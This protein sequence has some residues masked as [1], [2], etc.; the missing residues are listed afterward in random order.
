MMA[1]D[2][3]WR[4]GRQLARIMIISLHVL[5]GQV[6]LS[7]CFCFDANRCS[8]RQKFDSVQ[9]SLLHRRPRHIGHVQLNLGQVLPDDN[10]DTEETQ[11]G[12]LD[13]LSAAATLVPLVI[14]SLFF[15]LP[16]SAFAIDNLLGDSQII[17]VNPMNGPDPRYFLA[18][19]LCASISHGITTPIDVV[20]TRI[21]SDPKK[22]EGLGVVEASKVILQED[23]SGALLKGLAPTVVGY[24]LEGAAK[25]GLY[26]SLKPIIVGLLDLESPSIAYV[27]ASVVAGG[28]ASVILCPME[29]TRIRLVTDRSFSKYNLLTGIPRLVEESGLAS[30]F[31]GLPAMLSKQ[32]PYTLRKQVT[33]DAICTALYLIVT[34]VSDAST[35]IEVS[36][37]AASCASV[38]ACVLSQP[39]DVILT[40]TYKEKSGPSASRS[41]PQVVSKIYN[42][43]N[44]VN[45]F[46]SGIIA[47]LIQVGGIITSQLLLY[48]FI[49]QSLGL[50]ATGSS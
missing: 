10:G 40:E 37:V 45:G 26:E 28:V 9:G 17:A 19:G 48:D 5:L 20:K 46:Y 36:L 6:R 35:K 24:G 16:H 34:T 29:R 18:G 50:P 38:V 11:Q 44:G 33:Y 8:R 25:F 42:E 22:Y 23:G 41:F 2:A 49:K 1:S 4:W 15:F 43:R 39:G 21:Q 3:H 27:V 30:L 7:S 47:R 31:Y 12:P 13:G 14:T 32:C